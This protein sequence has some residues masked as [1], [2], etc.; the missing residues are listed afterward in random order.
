MSTVVSGG[1]LVAA[2]DGSVTVAFADPGGLGRS[3]VTMT[4]K[5]A[6]F[7]EVMATGAQQGARAAEI[8]QRAATLG[9]RFLRAETASIAA[10]SVIASCLE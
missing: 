10:L 4:E 6:H 5:R 2:P 1:R 8:E 3:G 7:A 9:P